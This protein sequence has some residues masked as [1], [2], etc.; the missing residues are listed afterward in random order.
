MVNVKADDG[1]GHSINYNCKTA[2]MMIL[3]PENEDCDAVTSLMG[4]GNTKEVVDAVS[5]CAG[6]ILTTLTK[7]PVERMVLGLMMT[8][9]IYMAA[10]GE[11]STETEVMENI[12][13]PVKEDKE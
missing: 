1:L 3:D 6:E 11:G 13:T 5:K 12:R 7:D 4:K 10:R 9:E 2:V 8:N